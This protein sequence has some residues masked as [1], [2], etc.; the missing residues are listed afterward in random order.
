MICP[1]ETMTSAL[2]LTTLG[3]RALRRPQL[4]EV[5]GGPWLGADSDHLQARSETTGLPLA[6][7]R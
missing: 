6:R 2:G 3:Q 1:A 7:K 5:I 4:M